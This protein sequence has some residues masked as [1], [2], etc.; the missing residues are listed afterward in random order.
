MQGQMNLFEIYGSLINQSEENIIE[1]IGKG[2]GLRFT[3]YEIQ[4]KYCHTRYYK[5]KHG[6]IEFEI[7]F[8]TY[9]D[10]NKM[11]IGVDYVLKKPRYKGGGSPCDSVN[12]A[13]DYI[14]K[15]LLREGI[16]I[17]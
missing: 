16:C 3:S 14:N 10:S 13:I 7:E 11:F 2:T 4:N 1:D 12:E 8:N 9:F 6:K 15:I 5:A 17:N